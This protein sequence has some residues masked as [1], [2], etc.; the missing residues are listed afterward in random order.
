MG[1]AK[2]LAQ[3]QNTLT[4]PGLEPRPLEPEFSTLTI[5]PQYVSHCCSSFTKREYNALLGSHS[6]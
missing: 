5:K 6:F 4:Q 3:E 1:R 2:F